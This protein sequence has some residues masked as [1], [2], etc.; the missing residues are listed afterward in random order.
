MSATVTQVVSFDDPKP[1]K[2]TVCANEAFKLDAMIENDFPF[3]VGFFN[4][5]SDTPYLLTPPS[6]GCPMNVTLFSPDINKLS[7]TGNHYL[8][9]VSTAGSVVDRIA[10]VNS[11]CSSCYIRGASSLN[12]PNES[13]S[14]RFP[15]FPKKDTLLRPI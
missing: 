15:E 14:V 4:P 1:N 9:L 11:G 6:P 13:F 3:S 7:L 12:I 2:Y 5:T 10:L 8:E